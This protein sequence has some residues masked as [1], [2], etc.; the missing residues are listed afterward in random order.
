MSG[1]I[2]RKQLPAE[3]PTVAEIQKRK[4][5]AQF[6]KLMWESQ[7]D[8][9]GRLAASYTAERHAEDNAEVCRYVLSLTLRGVVCLATIFLTNCQ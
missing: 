5:S 2:S 3:Q 6:I 9:S 8:G 7:P 1:V 4:F